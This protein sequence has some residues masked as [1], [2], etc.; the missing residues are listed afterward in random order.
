MRVSHIWYQQKLPQHRHISLINHRLPIEK[1]NHYYIQIHP[2][3][4][5][6][7]IHRS[8][9]TQPSIRRLKTLIFKDQTTPSVIDLHQLNPFNILGSEYSERIIL[10]IRT[11]L[12]YIG[13]INRTLQYPKDQGVRNRTS[14]G[15]SC[16][17]RIGGRLEWSGNGSQTSITVQVDCRRPLIG[18]NTARIAYY[19]RQGYCMPKAMVVS[20]IAS[21]EFKTGACKGSGSETVTVVETG[22]I[23]APLAETV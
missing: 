13:N 18:N 3:S 12:E 2:C 19:T 11:G 21:I 15:V 17:K 20:P 22:Q 8:I 23:P 14:N 16:I 9:P 10:I 1:P 5:L 4:S 6:F 7:S